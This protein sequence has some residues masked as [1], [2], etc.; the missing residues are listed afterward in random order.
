[1]ASKTEPR[2]DTYIA[3]AADFAQ[4]I[5]RHLRAV[6][7]EACPDTTETIK[8]GMPFFEYE[9]TL[10]HMAAFKRHCAFGFW[11]GKRVIGGEQRGGA[12]GQLGRIVKL[13]D[14][15][16]RQQLLAWVRKAAALNATGDKPVRP[17]KHP[18]PELAMPADFEAALQQRPDAAAFYQ[19]LSPSQRREFLEWLVEAKTPATR[20]RRLAQ[21]VELLAG[22]KTRNWKYR[23]PGRR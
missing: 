15:P 12:M 22:H 4:P 23:R 18:K 1:M 7:H 3:A 10:C 9:G 6:V 20:Q 16:D 11:N 21:S 17:P 14:L 19:T 8:W 13:D 2:V 5:L